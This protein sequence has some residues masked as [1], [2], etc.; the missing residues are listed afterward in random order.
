MCDNPSVNQTQIG[1]PSTWKP[2]PY[3]PYFLVGSKTTSG[4]PLCRI[5]IPNP[6]PPRNEVLN[7][8][9]AF[10]IKNNSVVMCTTTEASQGMC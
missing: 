5:T 1:A 2:R 10:G 3:D 4:K 7:P 6:M 8:N 9:V